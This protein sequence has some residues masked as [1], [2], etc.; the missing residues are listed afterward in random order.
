MGLVTQHAM[1][2][3]NHIMAHLINL[4]LNFLWPT[5]PRWQLSPNRGIWEKLKS[6]EERRFWLRH[7]L[8]KLL[9]L[10]VIFSAPGSYSSSVIMIIIIS[11]RFGDA[12]WFYATA[13]CLQVC[14]KCLLWRCGWKCA[15]GCLQFESRHRRWRFSCGAAKR[16]TIV[17]RLRGRHIRRRKHT[18]RCVHVGPIFDRASES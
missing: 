7:L 10:S 4:H 12:V 18:R 14:G 6:T 5:Q 8:E 16:T 2:V 9:L 17:R 13:A 15:G 11:S 3:V 1:W